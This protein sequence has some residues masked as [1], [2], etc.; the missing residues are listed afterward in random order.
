MVNTNSNHLREILC[1]QANTLKFL[2]VS[3]WTYE[4]IKHIDKEIEHDH[5]KMFKRGD[6]TSVLKSQAPLILWLKI[7]LPISNKKKDEV[8]YKFTKN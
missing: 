5:I 3:F 2:L 7:L 6:S 4:P 8:D 1:Q